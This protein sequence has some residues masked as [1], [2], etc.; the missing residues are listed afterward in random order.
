MSNIFLFSFSFLAALLFFRV[1]IYSISKPLSEITAYTREGA[2]LH[3]L[4][5]GILLVF[6]SSVLM[7]TAG[8]GNL[9]VIMLG[10]GLGM[11]MDE[12]IPSLY[13][14]EPEPL[15]TKLYKSSFWKTAFLF[16]IL[17]GLGLGLELLFQRL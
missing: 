12:F 15:V 2:K 3:H 10:F 13:L 14:P 5:Y 1:T 8:L 11:V 7:I 4:H 6:L 9:T 16:A 17:A